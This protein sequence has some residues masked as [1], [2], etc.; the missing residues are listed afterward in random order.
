MDDKQ[1]GYK[2]SMLSNIMHS[3]Y[4]VQHSSEDYVKPTA[5]RFAALHVQG[6][7]AR[8]AQRLGAGSQSAA[9]NTSEAYAN[10]HCLCTAR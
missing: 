4:G 7:A 6:A 5:L 8:A 3:C 9:I 2:L 10:N 1:S